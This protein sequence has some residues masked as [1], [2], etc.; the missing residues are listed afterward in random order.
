MFGDNFK[1][2]SVSFL[3]VDFSLLSCEFDNFTFKLFYCVILYTIKT[4]IYKTFKVP[5]ENSK[6]VSLASSIR[7]NIVAFPAL[8]F[9]LKLIC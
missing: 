7:K 1:T 8:K 9:A 6:V 2:T 5:C 3:I 4:K